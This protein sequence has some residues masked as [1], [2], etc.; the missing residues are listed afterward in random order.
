MTKRLQ[1]LLD[2]DQLRTIQQLAKARQQTTAAWVR[3]A[4]RVGVE[5]ETGPAQAVKLAALRAP[6]CMPSPPVTSTS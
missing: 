5:V 2:D 3:G 6:R 4:L 1:V